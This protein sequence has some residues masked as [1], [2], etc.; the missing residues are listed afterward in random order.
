MPDA[1][2]VEV[3]FTVTNNGN[4]EQGYSLS[5]AEDPA[6][7]FD[8]ETPVSALPDLAYYIDA[9]GTAAYD[10]TIATTAYDF[11]NPPELMP[12]EVLW[13]VVTQ[14][15]AADAVDGET[16]DVVLLAQ[17]LVPNTPADDPDNFITCLLYTSDA[18]DE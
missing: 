4:D 16:S 14:D 18:A 7:P 11:N 15:I 9:T 2:D 13:V 5:F 6:N 10:D 17:T 1:S 8:T 12:D 3:V